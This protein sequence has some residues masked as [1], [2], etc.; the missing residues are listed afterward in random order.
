MVL[1]VDRLRHSSLL[2]AVCDCN[3]SNQERRQPMLSI[4]SV[5]RMQNKCVDRSR[6][7]SQ[8]DTSKIV[9]SN[10]R[11][12]H[13]S[14]AQLKPNSCTGYA[15]VQF[16][17]HGLLPISTWWGWGDRLSGSIAKALTVP[18]TFGRRKVPASK[19]HMIRC[20]SFVIPPKNLAL[21]LPN[22]T[23]ICKLWQAHNF[24]LQSL[25]LSKL[26]EALLFLAPYLCI[27]IVIKTTSKSTCRPH[28]RHLK[29]CRCKFDSLTVVALWKRW[30]MDRMQFFGRNDH[31]PPMLR[32]TTSTSPSVYLMYLKK[33]S[34]STYLLQNLLSPAHQTRRRPPTMSS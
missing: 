26:A 14:Q 9:I 25:Y 30:L 2:S 29:V 27:L 24:N 17:W 5:S 8:S 1:S 23:R 19:F 7:F 32:R 20:T 3:F 10:K 33:V 28:R 18:S 31:R 13:C 4:S 6:T 16:W 15:R 21:H 22:K 11:S 34:S 12:I